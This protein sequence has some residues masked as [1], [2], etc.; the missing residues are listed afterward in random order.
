MNERTI[1]TMTKREVKKR[2]NKGG[3]E[4][5]TFEMFTPVVKF[6]LE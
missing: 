6:K 5:K 1:T 4:E 2:M 3:G